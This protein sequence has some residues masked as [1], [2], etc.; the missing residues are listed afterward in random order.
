MGATALADTV[1][2]CSPQFRVLACDSGHVS[3]RIPTER[4]RYRLCPHCAHWRQQRAITQLWPAIRVH[5]R[6]HPEDRWVFI[7]LT[8]R[9][10]DEPLH[11]RVHRLKRWIARLRRTAARKT[12]I[13]GAVGGHEV[14]HRFKRGW[15]V[16]VYFLASRQAWWDQA[17]RA[18]TWQRI[19]D[20]QG[21]VVD[22]Q[23]RDADVRASMCRPLTYPCKPTN[24]TAWGPARMAGFTALGRTKL[25][26]CYGAR[27][28]LIAELAEDREEANGSPDRQAPGRGLATGAPC[29][30]C[31]APFTAQWFTAEAV[32][33]SWQHAPQPGPA[34]STAGWLGG[35]VSARRVAGTSATQPRQ[36]GDPRL[37]LRWPCAQP[38]NGPA[39]AA[40]ADA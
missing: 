16:H 33:Q 5:S 21:E 37:C 40:E 32:H 7:T 8:A 6:R 9:A 29:P 23:D 12:A 19:T 27:R 31:G 14:T 35:Q 38:L 4:C 10:S 17:D 1:E 30:S 36:L 11:T 15:H 24:L 25:A 18:A 3:R 26:E 28:G 13:R 2:R 20:G 39:P 34:P 22:I